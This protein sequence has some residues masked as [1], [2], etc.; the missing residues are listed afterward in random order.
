[1]YKKALDN[2][3][4]NAA[5]GIAL[6]YA[7]GI[8]IKSNRKIA[9]SLCRQSLIKSNIAFGIYHQMCCEDNKMDEFLIHYITHYDPRYKSHYIKTKIAD[10]IIEYIKEKYIN[11]HPVL[12]EYWP[13]ADKSNINKCI[14]TLLLIS[15]YRKT[16]KLE[17]RAFVNGIMMLIISEYCVL[18]KKTTDVII[19]NTISYDKIDTDF[20]NVIS[21]I[22]FLISTLILAIL[23][24]L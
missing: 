1:L 20:L 4:K 2:G 6:M 22:V 16:S 12:H 19:H 3:K 24:Y 21:F 10:S 23:F 8:G 18:N 13:F 17:L 9:Y 15:K 11:W 14:E 7:Y 5:L